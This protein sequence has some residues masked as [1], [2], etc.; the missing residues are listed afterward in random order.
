MINFFLFK[1]LFLYVL[2]QE[3]NDVITVSLSENLKKEDPIDYQTTNA[4]TVDNNDEDNL[5]SYII[6][7]Y[8]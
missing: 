1:I 4:N 6:I 3:L 2:V 5:G 7:F 8:S